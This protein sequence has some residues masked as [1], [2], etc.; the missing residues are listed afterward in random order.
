MDFPEKN[1]HETARE[2]AKRSLRQAIVS[3]ELTPGFLY[4]EKELA[5]RLQSSRTPVREALMDMA[6]YRV[7]DVLPQ[8]GVRISLI[9]YK[10]ID[11]A[12]FA[13]ELIEC[14]ILPMTCEHA[15]SEDIWELRKNVEMQFLSETPEFRDTYDLFHLDNDFHRM[16]FRIAQREN[17]HRMLEDV[18][19]HFD[20]VRELSLTV[21]RTEDR[22]IVQDHRDICE[23]IARRDAAHACE[24]MHVHLNRLHVDEQSIRKA[25]PQFIAG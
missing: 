5:H 6:K 12:R 13:R 14:A 10:L 20:R 8:R 11:E 7:V 16:L 21:V 23:A 24:C 4:S 19:I 17:M 1:T 18:S 22:R 9:D 2:Y 15:T 25:Y 3:L